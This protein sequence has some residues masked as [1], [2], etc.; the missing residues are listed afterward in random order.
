[1]GYIDAEQVERLAEPLGKT[2]YGR[3]L[4]QMLQEQRR[5]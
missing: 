4:R 3:Y 5:R 2:G 1:M